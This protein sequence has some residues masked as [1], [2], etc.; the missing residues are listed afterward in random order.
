MRIKF[1]IF[2]GLNQNVN[3]QPLNK[4]L[5]S[6]TCS[7]QYFSIENTGNARAGLSPKIAGRRFSITVDIVILV[8]D[9]NHFSIY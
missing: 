7:T 6:S 4:D 8:L 9:I 5:K 2:H 1:S 3:D